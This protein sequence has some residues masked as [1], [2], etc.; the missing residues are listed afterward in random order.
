MGQSRLFEI[1][2]SKHSPMKL[3]G[4]LVL[5]LLFAGL[6]PTAAGGD[7]SG[8]NLPA[9]GIY[10][11]QLPLDGGEMLT[12]AFSVP[13]LE[14]GQRVP[15]ILALHYGGSPTFGKGAAYLKILA[16]PA[17]RDLG[18]LI[19]APDCPGQD[20][21]DPH[22]EAA[23]LALLDH[24]MRT[25]PVDPERT[26]VT[27]FSMGAMGAWY[28]AQEH[29]DRFRAAISVAGAPE[30]EKPLT[31]PVYAILSQYDD[32]IN[33]GPARRVVKAMRR[34]GVEA[35][36]V[37]LADGPT[38]YRFADFVLPLSRSTKWLQKVWSDPKPR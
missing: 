38:H 2:L 21:T 14:A 29:P 24:V 23:V 11:S 12:Y 20:W 28:L 4:T 34:E 37:L 9:P 26:A 33:G 22:S 13:T 8:S 16:E 19:L 5:S 1:L 27:G 35:K 6:C 25:W 15:L 18:A 31:I 32:V 3:C 30:H 17:F 36:L 7:T 10:G